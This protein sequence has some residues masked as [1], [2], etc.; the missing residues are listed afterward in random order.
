MKPDLPFAVSHGNFKVQV[1][2]LYL[3]PSPPH[4]FYPYKTYNCKH[5][6]NKSAGFMFMNG[7]YIGLSACKMGAQGI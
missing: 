1:L 4:T 3:A 7:L 2:I 5:L 6:S